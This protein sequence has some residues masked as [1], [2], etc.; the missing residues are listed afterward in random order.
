MCG[1]GWSRSCAK[2]EGAHHHGKAGWASPLQAPSWEESRGQQGSEE[3]EE[4]ATAGPGSSPVDLLP[5][6][7]ELSLAQNKTEP[8]DIKALHNPTEV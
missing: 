7:P 4:V 5:F 8:R 1:P 6:F 3:P 2:A